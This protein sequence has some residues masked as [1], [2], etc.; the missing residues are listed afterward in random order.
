MKIR[1]IAALFFLSLLFQ[2]CKLPVP[3]VDSEPYTEHHIQHEGRERL[4]L[5]HLP[6]DKFLDQPIPLLFC[7]HG[8]GGDAKGMIGFT[9]G[10]FN[11]LADQEG[12][13]VVYPQA[14]E[15]NWNDG[16]KGD[17]ATAIKENIDDVGF[18]SKIIDKLGLRYKIDDQAIFACGMS[19]GGFM[20]ARLACDKSD[21]FSGVAI[22]TATQG[23]DY[24]P[25]CK[26]TDPIKVMIMNGTADP[27]VPYDGGE[28]KVFR[29]KRG[30]I[31][32]TEEA[33]RFWVDHN[34][35]SPS[36]TKEE[37]P[38]KATMDG[39][40]VEKYTYSGCS[41]K[42]SVV[43]YKILYGGHTWPGA[44]QYLGRGLIGNTSRDINGCDEIWAFFS[45]E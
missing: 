16:R 29:K 42:S 35:C 12:F 1:N 31:I 8:G 17:F 3:N 43:L 10:R 36:P 21:V 40:K 14:V 41:P 37:L 23:V 19:N 25:L 4:Y 5:V 28:V 22:L 11:E 15:K 7:I 13:I 6:P 32:S 26:P 33:V 24:F 38:D 34:G 44:K 27:L 18:I 2:T 9:R 30:E 20:S 45:E 39:T